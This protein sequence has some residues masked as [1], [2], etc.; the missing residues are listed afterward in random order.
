MIGLAKFAMR[1]R[2]PA[3]MAATV[4]ALLALL[5][6][7]LSILSSA[8]VAL[9]TLRRGWLDGLLVGAISAFASGLLAYLLLGTPLPVVGF[10]LLLWLPVWLLAVLL[11]GSRSL[12]FVL[13]TA[14]GFGLLLLLVL[15]LQMG[16]PQLFWAQLLQPLAA[17]FVESEVM[18]A[19][20]S[21]AFIQAVAAWMTGIF[22]A[23]FYFQLVLALLLARSW[24]AR[25]YNPGGFREEFHALRLSRAFGWLALPL[26]GLTLLQGAAAPE[27]IRDLGVSIA[28]L[29]LLQGLAVVHY[30]VARTGMSVAWLV[31]LY[32]LL[33]LAMP[34]AAILV[35]MQGL[36]DIFVDIRSRLKPT[37]NSEQ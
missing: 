36:L 29:L 33:F 5:V 3:A 28:P 19:T 8:V 27:W 23:G 13:Q 6:P 12:A 21:Q 32:V 2:S 20:Q 35:A 16:E 7:L 22:T 25:L 17:G 18:D 26:L 34:H 10:L 37:I 14:F 1:G 31:A 24:Q 4:L 30:V 9:V 11:R 15:H